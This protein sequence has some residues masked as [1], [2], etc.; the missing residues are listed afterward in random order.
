MSRTS[1]NNKRQRNKRKK[2]REGHT[3]KDISLEHVKR[4]KQNIFFSVVD[5]SALPR[6]S[7]GWTG[8]PSKPGSL[9]PKT[10]EMEE[11]DEK[12]LQGIYWDGRYAFF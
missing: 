11:L 8:L 5:M 12:G 9:P 6:T 3:V 7:T 10:R 4:A 1:R 2:K